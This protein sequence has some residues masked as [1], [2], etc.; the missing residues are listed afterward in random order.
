M[1]ISQE[2]DQLI[3]EFTSVHFKSHMNTTIPLLIRGS[4]A[5]TYIRV[6]I[7]EVRKK[8]DLT[9]SSIKQAISIFIHIIKQNYYRKIVIQ[10]T[11]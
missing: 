1:Y 10:L 7:D 11:V 9:N 5:H 6:N 2:F 8:T 3:D 4:Q